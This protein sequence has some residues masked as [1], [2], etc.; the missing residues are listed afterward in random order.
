MARICSTT[1]LGLLAA[2]VSAGAH[3]ELQNVSIGGQITILGEYY[4]HAYPAEAELRRP[5]SWFWGRPLGTEGNALYS[6]YGWDDRVGGYTLVSQ[7]TRLHLSADFTDDVGVF[8]ECDSV[9]VWSEDFRS[10]YVSG[11]DARGTSVDDVEVYQAYVD[12]GNPFDLPLHLRLGRQEL[13][14]GSEW[15]AGNNDYGAIPLYGLSFDAVRLTCATE[16]VSLDAWWSKLAENGAVEEDGDVGFGGVYASYLG[17]ENIVFDGYWLWLRD[18]GTLEDVESGLIGEWFESLVGVD[19]YGTTNIH[20]AGLRAAGEVGAFDFD[21]EVAYQWG[22]AD[23]AGYLFRPV[24]YGDEGAEYGAWAVRVESGYTWETAWTPRI[25]AGYAYCGGEDRRDIAFET[26]LEALFNPFYRASSVSFNRLFSDVY[27][28][29]FLDGTDL[30]NVHVFSAGI[31]AMPTESLE[32]SLLLSHLR[33][34]EP[35]ARPVVPWIAFL[36]RTNNASLGWETYIDATY[37]YSD[38]VYFCAG[39][40]HLFAGEGLRRGH[41]VQANGLDFNGGSDDDDADYFFF[42]TGIIF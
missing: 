19:D 41:F 31:G 37:Y 7:W 33:A 5:A 17:L 25:H 23:R 13:A 21:A 36:S 4:R 29:N 1:P 6:G 14:F 10:N 38:D 40:S 2:L 22:D 15:L 26:W 16:A 8:I 3:A 20:T 30:S 34:D 35:F 24:L 32:M 28:S 18:A 39:W 11:V 9:G 27:L 42:E 12:A